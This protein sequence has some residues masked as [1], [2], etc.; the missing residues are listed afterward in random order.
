MDSTESNDYRTRLDT[1]LDSLTPAVIRGFTGIIESARTSGARVWMVGNGG[2]A[3]TADHFATDLLRCADGDGR[4]VRATSLCTNVGVIS[5]TANDHGYEHVFTRQLE[6]VATDGDVL[7]AISASG[8]SPNIV[9]AVRWARVNSL[10]TVGLTGFSGGV[11]RQLADV[12]VHVESAQGDYGVVE[13][14]HLAA[15]HM[16]AESLRVREPSIHATGSGT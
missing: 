13:D 2:S 3:T 11:T 9:S 10:I 15:C 12:S 4:P 5:A 8:N 7:V 1:A 16:A 6:M 14:A